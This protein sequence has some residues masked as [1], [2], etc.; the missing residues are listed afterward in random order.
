MG[1]S[2]THGDAAC[3]GGGG[4]SDVAL[5]LRACGTY[6]PHPR[7]LHTNAAALAT[8]TH[9]SGPTAGGGVLSTAPRPDGSALVVRETPSEQ[10]KFGFSFAAPGADDADAVHCFVTSVAERDDWL[11]LANAL[12]P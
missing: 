5:R 11:S 9:D 1:V 2:F 12:R 8:A 7:R 10:L 4:G 3:D 6:C